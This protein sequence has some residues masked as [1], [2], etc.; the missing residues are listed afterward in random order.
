MCLSRT[1][2]RLHLP[3]SPHPLHPLQP[4]TVPARVAISA[5]QLTVS[6]RLF[7]GS[8]GSYPQGPMKPLRIDSPPPGEAEDTREPASLY[9]GVGC[10]PDLQGATLWIT[11]HPIP[12]TNLLAHA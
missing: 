4:V 9:Q 5:G 10:Q 6:V 7:I 2:H 1:G 8:Q 3:V 12:D 11:R